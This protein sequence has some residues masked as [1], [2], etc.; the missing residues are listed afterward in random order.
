[1]SLLGMLKIDMLKSLCFER[2]R[3]QPRRKHPV[4]NVA[5]AT[6]GMLIQVSR[7]SQPR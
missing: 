5:L 6:E 2:A 7:P 1:M 3:L 4:Y